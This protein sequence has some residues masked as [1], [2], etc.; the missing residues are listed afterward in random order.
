MDVVTEC[1]RVA[2]EQQLEGEHALNK[3]AVAA[4]LQ[5]I[6]CLN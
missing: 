2:I 3:E 5:Q 4:I 6:I 1:Q